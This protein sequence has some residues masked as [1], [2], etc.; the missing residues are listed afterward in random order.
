MPTQFLVLKPV[1]LIFGL[2][3]PAWILYR[4]LKV[5]WQRR[6]GKNGYTKA[7]DLKNELLL[8]LFIVYVS[9]VL[10]ATIA[11]ASISGIN[12]PPL[13]D[14]NIIPLINTYK[15]FISTLGGLNNI[16]M[17]V[18]LE[19]II[20][21]I[22]LFIPLGIF[23]PYIFPKINSIKKLSAI[24]FLCS[25]SVELCQFVLR[26][27]G[28][29]RTSDIDDVIL[30]T[31]GGVLGWLVYSKF[32]NR[33]LFKRTSPASKHSLAKGISESLIEPGAAD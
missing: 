24:C 4:L 11:P 29:N 8:V 32:F 3:L 19:I 18:E 26:Q 31:I 9:T 13:P 30:N 15:Q 23:L 27:L 16:N 20:G 1:L 6:N 28:T 25:L 33:H 14:L 5:T 7:I 22:I 12:N 17:D 21:N 2:I 10:T